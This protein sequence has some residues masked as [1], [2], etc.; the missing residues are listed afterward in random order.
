MMWDLTLDPGYAGAS[1]SGA[2][3]MSDKKLRQ[4]EPT[5]YGWKGGLVGM[6]ARVKVKEIRNR[7][8][9]QLRYGNGSAAVVI[10]VTP[11]RIAAY[12]YDLDAVALLRFPHALV[13]QYDLEIGT[14]LLTTN[15]F[16]REVHED[17][18][19]DPGNF[20]VW[21]GFKPLI[22]DFLTDDQEALEECKA[23]VSALEWKRAEVL[24]RKWF[25]AHPY[26]VRDGTPSLT[27]DPAE[28]KA[29]SERE[30]R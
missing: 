2:L 26:F 15:F 22:A 17:L 30:L 4:L 19:D 6:I 24:G 7:I 10:S 16:Q 12:A 21:H 14:R 20:G 23:Q 29:L 3:P 25:D 1:N 5:L 18:T 28:E 8:A 11:L 13:K 9:G 27:G